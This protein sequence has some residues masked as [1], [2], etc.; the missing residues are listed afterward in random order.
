MKKNEWT[1]VSSM[2]EPHYGHAGT[3][4]GGLMYI[5]GMDKANFS[6]VKE[7]V[8]VVICD[9]CTF[10]HLNWVHFCK[11]KDDWFYGAKTVFTVK[12]NTLL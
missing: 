11:C 9:E 4:H 3:V 8:S 5:S 7:T 2:A 10:V 1:F 6:G 12:I